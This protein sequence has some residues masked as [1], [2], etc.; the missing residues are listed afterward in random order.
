MN[1]AWTSSP[2]WLI[3]NTLVAYR[4]TRLWIDDAVPPLPWLREKINDRLNRPA[5]DKSTSQADLDAWT[6]KVARYGRH[7][8]EYL[9]TCYWCAGFHIS[10]A[11]VIAA[12]LIPFTVWAFLALPFA[13]SAVVGLLGTRD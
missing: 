6:A 8:L 2:V 10:I 9:M 5:L 1:L 11:V 3:I 12:S 13:L 4:L 7:P